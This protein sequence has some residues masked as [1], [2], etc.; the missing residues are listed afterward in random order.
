[1]KPLS[2][3]A[4]ITLIELEFLSLDFKDAKTHKPS[5]MWGRRVLNNL[6]RR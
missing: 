5:K 4:P 6:N 2:L 3:N 1:L